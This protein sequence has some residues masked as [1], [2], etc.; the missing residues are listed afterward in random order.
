MQRVTANIPG[1]KV[2]TVGSR[3][4]RD[5]APGV[6]CF[7]LL[8]KSTVLGWTPGMDH[9]DGEKQPLGVC[10]LEVG[11]VQ[12]LTSLLAQ[13]AKSFELQPRPP[14]SS[15]INRCCQHFRAAF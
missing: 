3:A 5:L 14:Q 7:V 6:L 8:E 10:V 4:S 11:L 13:R 2:K 9:P 1:L 12:S 15:I